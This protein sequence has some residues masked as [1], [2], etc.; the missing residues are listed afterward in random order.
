MP[1]SGSHWYSISVTAGATYNVWWNDSY[2]SHPGDAE[3]PKKTV[4]V[5]VTAYY[6]DGTQVTGWLSRED[7]AWANP[8]SFTA[9]AG[10]TAVYLNVTPY[11]GTGTYGITFST[12]TTRPEL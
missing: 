12:G 8:K 7:S 2:Q 1:A 9:A 11:S 5:G 10:K 3:H 6:S 4:D